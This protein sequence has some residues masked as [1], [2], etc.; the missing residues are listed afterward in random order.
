MQRST[1][2]L[3][4]T[5]MQAVKYASERQRGHVAFAGL[6]QVSTRT[7]Q[8]P[9][10]RSSCVSWA[11]T[12]LICMGGSVCGGSHRQTFVQGVFACRFLIAV[13]AMRTF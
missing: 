12:R 13:V 2:T 6:Y 9:S 3:L 7:V 8:A 10:L 5:N 11:G 4:C 1:L